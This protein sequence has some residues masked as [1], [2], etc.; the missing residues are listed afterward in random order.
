VNNII[1]PSG[2]FTGEVSAPPSKSHAQ[3]ILACALL[4]HQKTTVLGIGKSTDELSALGILERSALKP[5]NQDGLLVIPAGNKLIFDSEQINFGESGLASRM[6]TPILA[7]A[8]QELMLYGSGTLSSR[9]MHLF[10]EVFENLKVEFQSNN[11]T[12]PFR[13]KGPIIPNSIELDGSLSSQFITGFLYAFAG[14]KE[15]RHEKL[16]L[17]KPKSL[18]YIELSLDVLREFGVNVNLMGEEIEFNG[19]YE[20]KETNISV[21]GDW[22]SASF[23]MVGAA[24]FGSIRIHGLKRESKQAD[25]RMLDVLKNFGSNVSWENDVLSISKNEFKSFEF[26]ATHCPDLFPPLAVLGSFG[27]N[28]SFVH[29]VHRLFAKES[30][31]AETIVE[32]LT[33]L[34][35]QI[36]IKGDAMLISPRKEPIDYAVRSCHDHRIA[37]ACAIFTLGIDKS[38]TISDAEAVD[39]SFPDF[40]TYLEHLTM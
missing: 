37:M 13:V 27:T 21:E 34:G 22:S 1:I 25:R 12:L 24:L 33:K 26:D 3:R 23:L 6:F 28:V 19:P 30:N 14:N 38:I 32:E 2:K 4:S 11:G 36:E 15:T 10:D 20:F 9:P 31:R 29:G 7:N 39:K 8:S 40:Y 18:P 35:A 16:R 5:S 17:K